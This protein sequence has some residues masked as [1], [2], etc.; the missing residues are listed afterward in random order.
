MGPISIPRGAAL[1]MAIVAV[2]LAV[3]LGFSY[4]VAVPLVVPVLAA[5][6]VAALAAG[7]VA[8]LWAAGFAA[9][10]DERWERRGAGVLLL[11]LAVYGA[12]AREAAL[13]PL[14]EIGRA[15]V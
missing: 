15:H 6:I 4:F 9:A 11:G 7:G 12:L 13:A 3:A 5:L 10:A 14:A 1:A 8:A 2:A